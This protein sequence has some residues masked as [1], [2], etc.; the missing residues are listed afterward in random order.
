MDDDGSKYTSPGKAIESMI[1]ER[2]WT[3]SDLADA[4]GKHRPLVTSLISGKRSVTPELAILLAAALDTS[5]EF[6]L[7]LE[8]DRQ[9]SL[10]NPDV[11]DV[12]RRARLVN[13]APIKDMIR[14]GWISQTNDLESL[15]G[16]LKRFF[17]VESIDSEP[18]VFAAARKSNPDS[19][20]N[21]EQRAWVARARQLASAHPARAPFSRDRLDELTKQLR[22]LAAYPKEC[23]EVADVLSDYG[24]RFVVVQPLDKCQ[25]DGAAFWVN[26]SPAIAVSL[27]YG[28][29]DAFWFTLMHE[30]AHIIHNDVA[31]VDCDLAGR[32][33]VPSRMKSEIERKADEAAASILIPKSDLESFVMMFSP[34]YSKARIN[35]FAHKVKI[36]PGIIVGQLQH[37]AELGWDAGRDSLV[38]IRDHVTSTALTDG[39]GKTIAP[40]SL[41]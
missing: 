16:E 31:S 41:D 20:L 10:V 15:E 9:L 19:P 28:R 8:G 11:E 6:W 29:I 14:R 5:P 21:R 37:R 25:I 2:G 30:L 33:Q 17:D 7:R 35:Q 22:R 1:S 12:A 24:V 39:W 4:I 38:D 40:G 32:G 26:D 3:H 34:L 36:H 23:T 18:Q 13:M 27:R